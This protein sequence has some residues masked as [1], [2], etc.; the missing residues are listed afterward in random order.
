MGDDEEASGGTRRK[1]V[2]AQVRVVS[3]D[4]DNTVW[5]TGP[6]IQA[7]N[8]ALAVYLQEEKKIVQPERTEVVMGRL[9]KANKA[10]YAPDE[11]SKGPVFLTKLR[12]D[13][14][15]QI[16]REHN[17]NEYSE[18]DAEKLADEAFRVW[19]L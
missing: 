12:K 14:V 15:F 6:T 1:R 13:A 19:C 7:A 10:D 11:G 16:L 2:A 8:D 17:N 9:F 18:E 4:L 3:F 5:K